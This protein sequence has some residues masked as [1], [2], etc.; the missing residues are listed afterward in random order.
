MWGIC[1]K[2]LLQPWRLF[3]GKMYSEGE[4]KLRPQKFIQL[5]KCRTRLHVVPCGRPAD[6]FD[7]AVYVDHSGADSQCLS[8]VETTTHRSIFDR[9]C[10]KCFSE[11]APL[12]VHD[13]YSFN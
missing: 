3:V 9:I 5:P 4:P 2:P 10:S 7:Q 1:S 13:P 11:R 12:C 6:T 8:M